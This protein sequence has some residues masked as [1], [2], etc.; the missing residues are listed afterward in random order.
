MAATS[1]KILKKKI[2]GFKLEMGMTMLEIICS[3]ANKE[4]IH[5]DVLKECQVLLDSEPSV[6]EIWKQLIL[7][8]RMGD[9]KLTDS[10]RVFCRVD[11]FYEIKS[12]C[13]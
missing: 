3:E 5:S 7:M 1:R 11:D 8:S 6:Y 13:H 12:K 4:H 9:D 2:V 10:L